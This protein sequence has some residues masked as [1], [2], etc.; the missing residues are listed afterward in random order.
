MESFGNVSKNGR[1]DHVADAVLD[2][3][4]KPLY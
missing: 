1:Q 4:E 2:F 3:F